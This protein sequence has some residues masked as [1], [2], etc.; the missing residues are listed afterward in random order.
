M[1]WS[2]DQARE[3]YN[4]SGW[5][6]G[7]IDINAAGH[8]VVRPGRDA[9]GA[10]VDLVELA[11]EIRESGLSWPLLVRCGGI[12][13]DRLDRLCGAFAQARDLHGY[14]GGYTAVYPIKVNQQA[15][16]VREILEHGGER[17]G[18]EAGSKPELMAVLGLSPPGGLVICNGYKDREY[19]RMALI[20][21][22]LGQRI[23]IVIE[24]ISEL[25]ELLEQ[26]AELD[27]APLLG[28]RV[29]LASIGAGNWQNTGGDKSKF[30]L[31]AAQVLQL[32]ERLRAAGLL[33]QLQLLHFHMG[34]QLANLGDIS[35]GMQEAGH[36]FVE[37][38]SLGA[39]LQ[40]VDI[41]GGLGV[42]YEGTASRSYCSMNYSVEQ[43]AAQVVTILQG[44]CVENQLPHPEIITESGRAM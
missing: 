17:V 21:R 5:S 8:L 16:V 26:V 36:F 39:P 4:L 6:D 20:A 35:K 22:K 10:E 37:L 43:Y 25:D 41:G 23:F 18:L 33:D 44:I 42:D 27:V 7:Y 32:V 19:I 15:S 13:R 3:C 29:R 11:G 30:G 9:T 38:R 28:V 1:N 34:S 14:S 2:I 31:H 24:K 12:L 40:V